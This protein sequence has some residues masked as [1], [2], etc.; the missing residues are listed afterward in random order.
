MPEAI[1][2]GDSARDPDQDIHISSVDHL[3]HDEPG[4][5]SLDDIPIMTQSPEGQH[6][7]QDAIHPLETI[8]KTENNDET[9]QYLNTLT[10]PRQ[11]QSL[12]TSEELYDRDSSQTP[13]SDESS[14]ITKT[15]IDNRKRR[16]IDSVVFA[17]MQWLRS[18]LDVWRKNAGGNSNSASGI[19]EPVLSSHLRTGSSNPN[20]RGDKKRKAAELDDQGTDNEDEG[21]NKEDPRSSSMSI[22]AREDLK[23][24]CPYFKYNPAKYKDWRTC[25][26][27]GWNDVHRVKCVY[28][29]H[30]SVT[31]G[32]NI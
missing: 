7:P 27:H 29:N 10:S 32:S 8:A 30:P 25:P 31:S 17:V 24:A 16:I 11:G 15:Y 19:S 2:R 22:Q 1:G 23:Y 5:Y 12:D 21:G 20:H 14:P 13:G 26:G 4:E 6:L 3:S 28:A 9:H 18:Y